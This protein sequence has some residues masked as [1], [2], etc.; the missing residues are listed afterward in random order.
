MATVVLEAKHRMDDPFTGREDTMNTSLSSSFMER[1]TSN[2]YRDSSL[3]NTRQSVNT[4]NS[5][6]DLS[7]DDEEDDDEDD[8][9]VLF[10]SLAAISLDE[11]DESTM[12]QTKQFSLDTF[13]GDAFVD[14]L[15]SAEIIPTDSCNGSPECSPSRL[16]CTRMPSEEP[17]RHYYSN[18]EDRLVVGMDIWD[19]LG[20]SSAPGDQEIGEIW[21]RRVELN[22][23]RRANI[24]NRMHRIHRLRSVAH[25][26]VPSSRHGITFSASV[27]PLERARTVDHEDP[28]ARYIGGGIDP[29]VPTYDGYDSDPEILSNEIS[30]APRQPLQGFQDM[31]DVASDDLFIRDIVQVSK[32]FIDRRRNFFKQLLLEM[33]VY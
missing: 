31:E 22:R 5:I 10:E 26:S 9:S 1:D 17:S 13:F 14:G 30:P 23:P 28:L 8:G 21:S 32:I 33:P 18:N 11:D 2:T 7:K 15:C 25:G 29:I 19:L 3:N 20:C 16:H 12:V 4:H 27:V 6:L 24:K